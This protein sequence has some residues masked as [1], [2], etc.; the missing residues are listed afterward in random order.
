MG[1]QLDLP[2]AGKTDQL[3]AIAA[4][5]RRRYGLVGQGVE[6]RRRHAHPLGHRAVEKAHLAAAPRRLLVQRVPL[7]QIGP[8]LALVQPRFELVRLFLT[9]DDDG[10]QPALARQAEFLEARADLLL[11]DFGQRLNLALAVGGDDKGPLLGAQLFLQLFVPLELLVARLEQEQF[12]VDQ[13]LQIVLSRRLSQLGGVQSGQQVECE[14]PQLLGAE[15]PLS[16]HR[17]HIRLFAIVT[18]RQSDQQ[19][20]ERPSRP[21]RGQFTRTSIHSYTSLG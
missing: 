2:L 1:R 8:T 17:N 19:S 20:A 14:L 12:L 21:P 16:H 5:Q 6:D 11:R 10:R 13:A 15:L 3:K 9:G 18:G 4:G 7:D